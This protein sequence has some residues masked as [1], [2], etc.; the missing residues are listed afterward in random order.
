MAVK[1]RHLPTSPHQPGWGIAG[2]AGIALGCAGPGRPGWPG[3]G[4]EGKVAVG[5]GG[6]TDLVLLSCPA[7]LT[8]IINSSPTKKCCRPHPLP[9]PLQRAL[10]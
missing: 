5:G 10:V 8:T 1:R 4:V 9:R 3:Q 7:K 6:G 2:I